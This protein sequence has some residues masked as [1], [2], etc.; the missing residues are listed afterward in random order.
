MRCQSGSAGVTAMP[1]AKIGDRRGAHPSHPLTP[2]RR[3]TAAPETQSARIATRQVESICDNDA[4]DDSG[5]GLFG[6]IPPLTLCRPDS[7][8]LFSV[9]CANAE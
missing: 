1:D 9:G 8:R 2:V 6:L 4:V 7:G 3:S 5:T